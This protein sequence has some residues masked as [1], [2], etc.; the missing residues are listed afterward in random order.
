MIEEYKFGS[1]TIDKKTYHQDVEVYWSGEVLR[2][3]RHGQGYSKMSE[4]Y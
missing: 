2:T 4:F 1:I 3:S